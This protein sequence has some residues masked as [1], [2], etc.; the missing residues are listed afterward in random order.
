MK[1]LKMLDIF[2]QDKQLTKQKNM[3]SFNDFSL[4]RN[5]GNYFHLP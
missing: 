1:I 5:P 3:I 2:H 4:S